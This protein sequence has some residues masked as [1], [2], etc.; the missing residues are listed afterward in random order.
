[1]AKKQKE[2]VVEAGAVETIG[3]N[4]VA[5]VNGKEL[6]IRVDLSKRL[7]RSKSGKTVR[8]ASTLGNKVI[9]GHDDLRIGLNI[10]ERV[11]A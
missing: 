9:P 10:Y 4:V 1:M 3:Q 2:A 6:V 8:I 5:E 7:G 11:E